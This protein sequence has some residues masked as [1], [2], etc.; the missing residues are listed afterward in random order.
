MVHR[1][2]RRWRGRLARAAG[3]LALSLAILGGSMLAEAANSGFVRI[4]GG[5]FALNGQ[6]FRFASTNAYF[7]VDAASDGSARHT[8]DML[9][10]AQAL[11]F[12]VLRSWAF[13]DGTSA[14]AGLQPSAGVYDE[15][16][17][18]ALDYV[19]HRADQ[20]NV[21]LLLALVNY[22]GDYGGVPQYLQWC[23]PGQG[24]NAFYTNGSCRQLY[25][26]YVS[27]VLNRVNTYNG[28]RY[29]DDPTIFGWELMNEPR[30]TDPSGQV[31]TQWM[32]EMASFVKSID[33]NHLV[34]TGEEGFDTTT[35]GYSG[36]SAYNNQGWLFNGGVGISFSANTALPQIDFASIHVYPD[37]WNLPAEA[38]STW[39]RDHARKARQLGKPLVVGEF[40]YHQ[41]PWGVL[42]PWLQ[43]CE[44]EQVGGALI[45]QIICSTVCGNY[46]GSLS[47][48][49]PPTSEVASGMAQ[50]A[51]RVN[52]GGGTS[53]PVAA[54]EPTAPD[55]TLTASASPNPVAPGQA[56][57]VTTQVTAGAAAS[58]VHVD[59]EVYD[60]ADQK[61][62]Q[63]VYA[64]QSFAAGVPRSFTWSWPGAAAPGQYT[65]R[66][67]VF[68]AD[69]G[70]VLEWNSQAATVSVQ[71]GAS[72][73]TDF[74]LSA[75]VTPSA[76]A[77]NQPASIGATV[78]AAAPASNVV[79]DVELYDAGGVKVGYWIWTGQYFTAGQ[80]RS[81]SW[82]WPG[83]PTPGTYTVKVGV[84]SADWSTLHEWN[85][86]AASL[87][88]T[89]GATLTAADL[90][91]STSL[92][93]TRIRAGQTLTV[94][95]SV[96]SKRA[97][98]GLQIDQEIYDA[99][100]TRVA[101]NVCTL[102]FSAGQRRTCTWRYRVQLPAGTYTVKLG[103]FSNDWSVRYRW[104][105]AAGTV[106]V[107]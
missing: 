37:G 23:A 61:V 22:W 42:G 57:S 84:F 104:Y 83:T 12:T 73:P 19:L 89:S 103:L 79:V 93:A 105:N 6:S 102:T 21:R 68:S 59:V 71:S 52:G 77:P 53:G 82:S 91:A 2:H 94:K 55:F 70:T 101:Q 39:I 69:W 36:L 49:F 30:S 43:T 38:G 33:P 95:S 96:R 34:G 76:V 64:S 85:G 26:N 63:Q 3:P 15:S 29:R 7:L 31:V 8:D 17:F 10:A 32:A 25:K 40:G 4:S 58:G 75:S 46:G 90:T 1:H 62:A 56:V 5:Q 41:S 78:K 88:V 48:M 92:S 98:S 99:A 107:R 51:A 86:E 11:G 14:G 35:S 66:V 54:P 60:A 45:W 27:Y 24:V 97:V 74:T 72:A 81:Y 28:R 13:L 65:V 106:R 18:R 16:A 20:A 44:D 47:T 67:G 87:S 9:Q 50:V 80:T 100:G